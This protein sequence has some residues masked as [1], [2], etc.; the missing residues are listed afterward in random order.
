MSGN[1]APAEQNQNISDLS[2]E[3]IENVQSSFGRALWDL[4]FLDNFYDVFLNSNPEIGKKFINT[5]FIKQK[6]LLRHGLM[7]VL[8]F[9]EGQQ[10]AI[11]CLSRIR[12]SHGHSKM[13]IS[14]DLYPY[15]IDSL[16]KTVARCDNK[17]DD[18]LEADWR[19]VVAPAVDYIK[20]GY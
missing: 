5:D 19:A 4:D 1:T 6:E 18:G 10:S 15:W 9:A 13:N 11:A 17:F 14:P 7:S 8:M 20:S 2:Q 16:I 3:Q 12:E